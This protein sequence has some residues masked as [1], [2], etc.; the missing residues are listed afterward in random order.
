MG[1]LSS[2]LFVPGSR[3]DRFARAADSGADSICI[4]LED[5]V[6]EDDK[7]DARAAAIEALV[8]LGSVG[9]ALRINGLKTAAGLRRSAR[10]AR[11]TCTA[12]SVIPADG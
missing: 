6:A 2:I 11:C 4:D 7:D 3:P 1:R 12:A 9:V 5:A 8:T 10:L